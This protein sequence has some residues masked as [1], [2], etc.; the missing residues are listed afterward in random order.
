VAFEFVV[1]AHHGC[2]IPIR[3]PAGKLASSFRPTYL[4]SMHE[5][6]QL[7]RALLRPLGEA[8]TR[9]RM[10]ADGDR[11]LVALSGGKDS[12]AL[13]YLLRHLQSR[14]PVR[15]ELAAVTI[16]GGWG[17]HPVD[18]LQ[19]YCEA[20]DLEL[21]VHGASIVETVSEKLDE[22]DTPCPLCARLR[23][24]AIYRVA[25]DQGFGT[26]ALGHHA[27][28]L[29]E[30]LLLNQ[31]FNGQLKAMPP[32]LQ[33]DD[34]QTV[35]IRPLLLA[36]EAVIRDFSRAAGIPSFPCQCLG[37]GRNDLWRPE[38]KKLVAE[39]DRRFPG[40]RASMR[41]ATTQLKETTL[42][43]PRWLPARDEGSPVPGRRP[44]APPSPAGI[45]SLKLAVTRGDRTPS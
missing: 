35:A 3:G 6:D 14:A 17:G 34:G 29:V 25:R 15:Y 28:D 16:D 22:D 42:A 36:D 43:D 44:P 7:L 11:V 27:D 33:A 2:M 9:Y 31:L 40:A 41:T 19:R 1:V 38:I 12:G 26:V 24:G 5:A 30:T 10:I 32:I 37:A 20:L 13:L 45:R 8:I 21:F 23:R 4:A 18:P 39:L